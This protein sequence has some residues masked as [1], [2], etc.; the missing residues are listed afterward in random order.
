LFALTL[1]ALLALPFAVSMNVGADASVRAVE[2]AQVE[3]ASASAR[4]LLLADAMLSHPSF[5]ET[6]AYDGLDEFPDQLVVPPA[7]AALK[8]QDRVQFGGEL[9]DLSR[10]LS[11]DAATPMLL[12][13]LIGTTT[14]LVEEL[15]PEATAMVVEDATALPESG[16]VWLDHEV[17]RYGGKRGNQLIDLERAQFLEQGFVKAENP[18]AATALVLDY[19]CVIAAAWP[20]AGRGDASRALRRP[21]AAV[22]EL[23]EIAAAGIGAFTTDEL[24]RFDAALSCQTLAAN[25]ATWGRPERVFD[26]LLPGVSRSL[27]VKSALHVGAGSTVRLRNLETGAVEYGLVMRATT[28]R[29]TTDLLLPSVFRLELLNPVVHDF[30]PVDTV[31]EP[32]IPPP[33]NLNTASEAVLTALFTEVRRAFDV[34]VHEADGRQ[35]SAPPLAIRRGQAVELA[36]QIVALRRFD[37]G[38]VGTG[39]FTGWKDLVDRLI[40]PRFE[41]ATDAQKWPWIYLYRNLRTG[42]DSAIEMGTAPLCFASGSLFGF[43]AAASRSRS[44]AAAGIAAR[45]ERTGI[46]AVVPGFR[47]ERRWNTQQLLE[48]AFRLDRRAPFWITTPENVG[49]LQPGDPGN[50]PS[51]R[52]LPHLIPLAFGDM[53]FGAPR[54]G[55]DDTVEAAFTPAPAMNRTGNTRGSAHAQE[56]F[57]LA[58]DPRGRDI[59]REGPYQIANT[60][61]RGGPG[62][63]GGQNPSAPNPGGQGGGGG[64]GGRHDRISLPFSEDNGFVARFA[65]SFWLEPQTLEGTTLFDHSDGDTERNRIALHGRDGNL[66]LEVIDEAG[67]DPDP[68]QSPSGVERTAGEFTL[69]LAELALPADTPVHV[70]MSAYS[71]RPADLSLFVDGVVRGKAKY[72]TFLTASVPVFDPAL[73]NNQQFPPTGRSDKYLDIQVEST[74]GFPQVGILRIG[75]E[76]FEYTAISGNTFQC[77][78]RDSI[79]GRGARQFAREHRPNVPVDENGKP[80]VDFEALQSQGVNLDVFPEHPVGSSVELYGYSALLSE[81]SPMMP[82]TTRLDGGVGGFS[83]ARGFL[84]NP[85]PITLSLP[86]LPPI[87]L[88]TGL[89]ETWTGDLELADPVPTKDYPPADAQQ[90]ISDGFPTGGGYAL[91]M[92]RRLRFESNVPGQIAVTAEVG[93]VELIRYG[94]RSGNKLKDVQRAQTLPG[95]DNQIDN[96]EYQ[97]GTARQF[98]TEWSRSWTLPNSSATWNEVPTLILWVVPVSLPVQNAQALWDPAT[99]GLTEWVQLYPQGGDNNDTEWVRYD[100]LVDNKHIVRGNRAAWENTRFTLTRTIGAERVQVGPLGPNQGPNSLIEPPW[101]TVTA[102]SGYIGYIPTLES[103]FPQIHAARVSLSFRGDTLSQ[104]SSHPQS[105]AVVMQC[106][107]LQLL[108]GNFSALTGRVGRH[109]RVAIVQGSTASGDSRPAVEWHTCNWSARRYN[110]DQVLENRNPPERLGPWPFQLVAFTDGVQGQFIGPPTGT[111]MTEPRMYD[112]IVKFPSGELPAA[113]CENVYVGGA[114]GGGSPMKGFVD[115]IDVLRHPAFDLVLDESFADSAREFRVRPNMTVNAAGVIN[116]RNDL[117]AMFPQEGGLVS[118]GGEILA[119][120]GRADGVFTIAT[121]GRGL[122]NTEPQGHDRGDRVHFLT[123][124]P[125][126]IL[127]AGVGARDDVLN[128][129]GLGA[130]PSGGGTVLLGQEL[131][132]YTWVRRSGDQVSLE[133][134]RWYPAGDFG[135]K[136]AARGLFRGRYGTAAQG[137]SGGEAVIHWPFRYWDRYVEQN[138][139][140]EL[141]YFQLTTNEAPCF[142]RGMRWREETRDPRVDVVCVVR[143]DPRVPWETEPGT[144]PGL[145]AFR[146]GSGDDSWQRIAAQSARLEMRFYATYEAGAIDLATFTAH[147]WKTTAKVDDVR[148]DYEGQSRILDEQV[149]AR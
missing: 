60:G 45:H 73:A 19:R 40:A 99:S 87:N 134:P 95:N 6:P 135:N 30:G 13:N 98:V 18:V 61:P 16:Y 107:R 94:S 108:L 86:R 143:T 97:R 149:T 26:Q 54:Y 22:A 109:D 10:F 101:G 105:N 37:G 130:L 119:Y 32:L 70:D 124:R 59:S 80:T 112:R 2:R 131:L 23:A 123:H 69:P 88:G 65:A 127:N 35:R 43:R 53:G 133:M 20:F 96:N 83:V 38:A 47:L 71:N 15:V 56:S 74:E 44:T 91:L 36:Q 9:W 140:P 93:G 48:E 81:D 141:A 8:E 136:A 17:I 79:G 144:V 52:Y 128:L 68:S 72:L 92:Q 25:A 11:L 125:A 49:A 116:Y 76:L 1:L 84:Q 3:Q 129:Q 122:L 31:V 42:R 34:R 120:Q 63:G 62:A 51:A 75:T 146:V 126:A 4:D 12:S 21:Y 78:W 132:H 90:Q 110:G 111:V 121:N 28:E 66:V 7:F 104:T 106:Q 114:V 58:I 102:T 137:A 138:D 27:R 100:A 82:G 29:S 117:S 41:G 39:P 145:Y 147:A 85:R 67:L 57:A 14:R 113:Y 118:I 89:D 139:D 5:D 64:G 46:A 77:Q 50:D 24:D 142:F 103:T 148:V 33:V 55:S 115:E